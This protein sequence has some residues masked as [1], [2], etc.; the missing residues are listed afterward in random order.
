VQTEVTDNPSENRFEIR[1]DGKVPGYVA[2]WSDDD[3][4]TLTHTEVDSAYEGQGLGSVLVRG[5]L[6]QLRER[7]VAVVPQCP[8]VRRFLQ[9]HPDYLDLVSAADRDRFGLPAAG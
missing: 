2:Y 1:V 5:T 4:V 8:F 7:G 3:K 6:D 9:R